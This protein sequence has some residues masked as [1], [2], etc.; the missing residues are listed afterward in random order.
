MKGTK[1]DGV[2]RRQAMIKREHLHVSVAVG[3]PGRERKEGRGRAIEVISFNIAT[4]MYTRLTSH[5]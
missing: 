3:E 2:L 1:R 5:S 4:T